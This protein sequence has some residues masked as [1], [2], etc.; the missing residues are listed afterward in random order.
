[1][2]SKTIG[3]AICAYKG[4][5]PHLERLF[6]SIEAQTR[7]PDMVVVSCSSTEPHEMP[8]SP[9]SYSFPL[10]IY[11]HSEKKNC[12]QNRNHAAS[13]MTTDVVSFMDA[14]DVMHPQRIEIILNSFIHYDICIFVHNTQNYEK[15]PLIEQS[16]SFS[17]ISRYQFTMNRLYRCPWGSAQMN[18]EIPGASGSVTCGHVSVLRS[19]LHDISFRETE[20]YHGR[21]DTIFVTDV[22]TA[23]PNKNIYCYEKLSAYYPSRTYGY[24]EK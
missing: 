10:F 6:A 11:T 23:Y 15:T 22:I 12:A 14:D 3:L 17:P 2:S 21:D 18:H 5:I 13:K 1:M 19:V 4:H 20:D 9:E 8:Y 24:V 16:V 7:K